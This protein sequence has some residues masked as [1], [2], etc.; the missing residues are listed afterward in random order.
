M[1]VYF[2]FSFLKLKCDFEDCATHRRRS[3]FQLVD[4]E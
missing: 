2:A 3:A 1:F 4:F